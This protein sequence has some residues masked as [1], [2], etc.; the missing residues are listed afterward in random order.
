MGTGLSI[1]Q[2]P[3]SFTFRTAANRIRY[4][5][6]SWYATRVGAFNEAYDQEEPS[7]A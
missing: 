5:Y 3:P 4:R 2:E 6:R 1:P 7:T